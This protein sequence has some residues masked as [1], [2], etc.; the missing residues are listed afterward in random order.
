MQQKNN[1]KNFTLLLKKYKNNTSNPEEIKELFQMIKSGEE[2]GLINAELRREFELVFPVEEQKGNSRS[3]V[4]T[5]STFKKYAI[6]I[7][8]SVAL[9]IGLYVFFFPKNSDQDTQQ[10]A[11]KKEK[12]EPMQNQVLLTLED[13]QEIILDS[14]TAKGKVAD[15]DGAVISFDENGELIYDASK[16]SKEETISMNKIS[17][18]TGHSFKIVLADGS[19]V[20][21]NAESEL[22]FPSHFSEK[23]RMISL[24]GEGYFEVAPNK[25]KPFKVT[26]ESGE[27]ITVLGTVFNVMAYRNEP[28]KKIT[29]LEGSIRLSDKKKHKILRPGQQAVL[30]NGQMEVNNDANI[31]HEVAWKNGLFDFQNDDLSTIARQI[32]RWYKVEIVFNEPSKSTGHFTGSIRKSAG[33]KEVLKMLEV[34]GDV[35]F[36]TIGRKI[37]VNHKK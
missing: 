5:L 19:N 37:M 20:W 4:F 23:Q 33:I 29:L 18:P 12:V 14:S 30:I 32:S 31:D 6:R 35:H 28:A 1:R 25:E 24:K 7:A 15:L 8:A 10:L 2:D 3:K 13:G 22:T 21:L 16:V 17:T 9:L 26:L 27:E 36:T 11:G 34:A